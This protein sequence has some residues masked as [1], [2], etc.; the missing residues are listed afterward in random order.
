M[1]SVTWVRANQNL[2]VKRKIGTLG[3]ER[4]MILMYGTHYER[5]HDIIIIRVLYI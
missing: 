4:K 2:R 1:D 5:R 3:L